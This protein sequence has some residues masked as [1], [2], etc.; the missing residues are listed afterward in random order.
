MGQ[1]K[2]CF[3]SFPFFPSSFFSSLP[4]SLPS[5]LH[6]CSQEEHLIRSHQIKK[7]TIQEPSGKMPLSPI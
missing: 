5:Y 3:F 2:I 7:R 4:P 6:C 1:L